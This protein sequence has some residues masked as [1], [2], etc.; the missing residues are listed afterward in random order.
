MRPAACTPFPGDNDRSIFCII[1]KKKHPAFPA[2]GQQCCKDNPST[3]SVSHEIFQQGIIDIKMHKI[4]GYMK[5][6]YLCAFSAHRSFGAPISV[7]DFTSPEFSKVSSGFISKTLPSN[8][9]AFDAGFLRRE[10]FIFHLPG[11]AD[12]FENASYDPR[13]HVV[14]N[15]SLIHISEPTRLG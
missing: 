5:P 8:D 12:Q 3:F 1:I 6:A 9:Q 15:L 2:N 4:V 13:R 7:I 10:M 11:K 14:L